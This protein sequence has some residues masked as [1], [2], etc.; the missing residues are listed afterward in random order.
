MRVGVRFGT[1]L[2][3]KYQECRRITHSHRQNS[4]GFCQSFEVQET[5]APASDDSDFDH[6]GIIIEN[7]QIVANSSSTH[8][9]CSL[10]VVY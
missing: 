8:G 5:D 6:F 3:L 10:L 9:N 2:R 1:K 4:G 7:V